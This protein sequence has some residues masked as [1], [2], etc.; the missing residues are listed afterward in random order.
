MRPHQSGQ[1]IAHCRGGILG[2]SGPQ[3]LSVLT[4]TRDWDD[5][6]SLG[7]FCLFRQCSGVIEG[8]VAVAVRRGAWL[9]CDLL[10][11]NLTQ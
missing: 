11:N 5:E 9:R 3:K 2:K 1:N 10:I 7:A 8:S 4:H 6:E